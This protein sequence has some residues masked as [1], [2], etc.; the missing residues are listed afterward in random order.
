[1]VKFEPE[2]NL[3]KLTSQEQV[4]RGFTHHKYDKLL[5]LPFVNTHLLNEMQEARKNP[6]FLGNLGPIK[7]NLL[8]I[9]NFCVTGP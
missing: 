5:K 9:P 8:K 4:M 7:T 6:V 2:I 3:L 1:M